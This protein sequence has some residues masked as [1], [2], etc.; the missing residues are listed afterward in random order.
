MPSHERIRAKRKERRLTQEQL[1]ARLKECWPKEWPSLNASQLSKIENGTR[2]V[3]LDEAPF[4]ARAL[5]CSVQDLADLPT[6]ETN[7]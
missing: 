1:L 7:R 4:F 5:E 2:R 3:T 6:D